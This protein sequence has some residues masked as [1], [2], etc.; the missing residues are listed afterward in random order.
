MG[1]GAPSRLTATPG[2]GPAPGAAV[3]PPGV[4]RMGD[5]WL[6]VPD[7]MPPRE[8]AALLVLLHGAGGSGRATVELLGSATAQA[9]VLVLAPDS[10]G[11]TW[12][13]I[14]GGYGPDVERI[15]AAL[16]AVYAAWLIDP[17][18]TVLSGFSD[19]ASYALS[20]G[21]ANGDRFSHIVAFSPGFMA[22]DAVHGRPPVYISH[23]VGD[24]VLPIDVCSRRL[25]PALR[26]SGYDVHYT[27]FDGG[28]SVPPEIARE[29]LEWVADTRAP[30][31]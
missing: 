27:E 22:P 9:N 8:P 23:G 28:H 16:A 10:F 30:A 31:D 1:D 26:R 18:Q 29:A 25:V 12:D 2:G 24:R 15:D 17:S 3:Q 21:V 6:A 11:A 20:L 5:A 4:H 19:G 7:G 13:V 14:Q